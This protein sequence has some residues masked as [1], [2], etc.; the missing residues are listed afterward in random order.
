MWECCLCPV[1][2]RGTVPISVSCCLPGA[3]GGDHRPPGLTGLEPLSLGGSLGLEQQQKLA[4]GSEKVLS[5][6]PGAPWGPVSGKR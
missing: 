3:S 4:L 6:Y 2:L 5:G 1:T